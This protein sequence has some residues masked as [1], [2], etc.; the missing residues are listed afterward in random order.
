MNATFPPAVSTAPAFAAPAQ[1]LGGSAPAGIGGSSPTTDLGRSVFDTLRREDAMAA[2]AARL[3]DM[4]RQAPQPTPDQISPALPPQ[5]PATELQPAALPDFIDPALE[6]GIRQATRGTTA[7]GSAGRFIDSA[8]RLE[9]Q[10]EAALQKGYPPNHPSIQRANRLINEA[11]LNAQVVTQ[12][13]ALQLN[14]TAKVIESATSS[15]RTV[16]QTQT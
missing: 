3:E 15:L 11:L 10:I 5:G 13:V 1:A 4:R 6:S 16:L 14:A 12:N 9:S 7:L 2:E 8:H